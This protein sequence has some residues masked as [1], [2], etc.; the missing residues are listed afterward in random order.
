MA[1]LTY[2]QVR[3]WEA[4]PL[5]TA[6]DGVKKDLD[7]LQES[8]DTLESQA[9]PSSWE[10][11]PSILAAVRRNR[12]LQQMDTHLEG[13]RKVKQALYDA[14]SEVTE[15][16]RLVKEVE[17]QARADEISIGADGSLTDN[18]TPPQF[19][20][21]WEAEEWADIRQ[22]KRAAISEDITTLLARAAAADAAIAN[23]IPAGHVNDV[24]ERGTA[25]PEVA[26][27]WAELTDAE[28]QAI[29]AQIV[30]ELAAES[31]IENP[32]IVW[33]PSLSG[34]GEWRESSGTIAIN[35]DRLDDPDVLHTVAHEVRHAR[36]YEAI[37]DLDD[38]T[39]P[40]EDDAFDEHED[41]GITEEQAEEWEENFDDYQSTDNGDTFEEYYE[42]PVEEDA[43][44]GGREFLDGLTEEEL[45]RLLEESR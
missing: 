23:S 5:G 38:W 4:K 10:G 22:G 18:S 42:Q 6:G 25:S 41:D 27:R 2:G 9:I 16:E 44:D 7:A 26:A 32:E 12:L 15:I 8:R 17:A 19:H 36:Q 29:I 28:R 37:R 3:S 24:D 33:D 1:A 43:R 45:D 20:S 21:K 40:W 13:K 39:W 31:G 34:N 35:P 14:E 11:W 30:E